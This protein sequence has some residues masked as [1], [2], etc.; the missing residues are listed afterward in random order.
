VLDAGVAGQRVALGD[1]DDDGLGAIDEALGGTD[2]ARWDTDGDG[3]WDG[4]PAS[5]RRPGR[6]GLPPSF[7]VA[8]TGRA[9]GP[10]GALVRVWDG[11]ASDSPLVWV[12]GE[13]LRIGDHA[14]PRAPV[15]LWIR[16]GGSIA[17]SGR[18]GSASFAHLVG[19][20]LVSDHGCVVADRWT[21]LGGNTRPARVRAIGEALAR[22]DGVA[23]VRFGAARHRVVLHLA[24]PPQNQAD[25]R[26][27]PRLRGDDVSE[28]AIAAWAVAW[29]RIA[30]A[31]VAEEGGGDALVEAFAR[32]F[33]GE[34]DAA[35]WGP[36]S[37]DVGAWRDVAAAC[38]DGWIGVLD[39]R[40]IR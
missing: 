3:W 12:D 34:A 17:L 24:G 27:P 33:V 16:P 39:A 19:I 31:P 8:C 38:P 37:R 26:V 2:P 23:A 22:L 21:V 9:A 15:P 40:C 30:H 20:G 32:S 18:T 28:D 13:P 11:A 5:L 10:L 6:S 14:A 25:I 7:S 1:E 29:D 4:A 36:V 35:P